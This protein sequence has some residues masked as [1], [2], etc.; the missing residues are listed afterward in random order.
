MREDEED[1]REET[2]EEKRLRVAKGFLERMKREREV[3][4]EDREG[5]EDALG[6][7]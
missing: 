7:R 4:D 2:A 1:G 6:D 5:H 3:E